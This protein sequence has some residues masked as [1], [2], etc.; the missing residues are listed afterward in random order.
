VL[1]GHGAEAKPI[2]QTSHVKA[3]RTHDRKSVVI[4]MPQDTERWGL[5]GDTSKEESGAQGRRHHLHRARLCI[6]FTLLFLVRLL[7][8]EIQIR[9]EPARSTYNTSEVGFAENKFC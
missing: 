5:D 2:Q 3:E 4:F 8:L 9:L 6:S 7:Y 1:Q